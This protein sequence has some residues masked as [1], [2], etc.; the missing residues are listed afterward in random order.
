M[1]ASRLKTTVPKLCGV[2]DSEN[3][4]FSLQ[5]KMKCWQIVYCWPFCLFNSL[6]VPCLYIHRQTQQT[7]TC[8]LNSSILFDTNCPISFI[9]STCDIEKKQNI[10]TVAFFVCT[11]ENLHME[12]YQSIESVYS[13]KSILFFWYHFTLSI[14][15]YNNF[16]PNRSS[17]NEVGSF[18]MFYFLY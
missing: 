13:E 7:V 3:E 10:A 5:L 12:L 18:K 1:Y 11:L 2:W 8:T 14:D 15:L 16:L 9:D 17:F 4:P 6:I